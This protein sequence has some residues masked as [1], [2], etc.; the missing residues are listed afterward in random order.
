M[1]FRREEIHL[2]RMKEKAHL[3]MCVWWAFSGVFKTVFYFSRERIHSQLFF[4]A[5]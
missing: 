3:T 2:V 5:E 4:C 1:F